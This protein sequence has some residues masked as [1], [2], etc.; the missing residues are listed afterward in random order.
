MSS[1]TNNNRSS[2]KPDQGGHRNNHNQDG[3]RRTRG[4]HNRNND[5]GGKF[6][7]FNGLNQEE[8]KGIV[9]T[10]DTNTPTSQQFDSLYEALIVLGGSK[11]PQ[12]T[13]ALRR[14]KPLKQSDFMP[15]KPRRAEYITSEK[16]EDGVF[17]EVEDVILSR[18]IIT[19]ECF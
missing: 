10:D 1:Q 15:E 9:I 5:K 3:A 11:N 2:D 13:T 4:N 8:L 14:L 6:K 18:C 19:R 7:K 17:I 12:V 16:D